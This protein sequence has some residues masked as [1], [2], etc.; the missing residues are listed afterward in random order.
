LAADD[1]IYARRRI[2][3]LTDKRLDGI[4]REQGD[5]NRKLEGL[6][7][8]VDGLSNRL[9]LIAGGLAVLSV[10]ANIVG[11]AIVDAITRG[12]VP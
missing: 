9:N 1:P 6:G 11:P 12:Q 10:L 3:A 7:V 4:E 2:D 5:T 8:K